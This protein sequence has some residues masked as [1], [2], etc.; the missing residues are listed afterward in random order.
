[1]EQKENTE[2]SKVWKVYFGSGFWKHHGRDRAGVEISVE[3]S[4]VWKDA[5][6]HVPAVYVCKA[7]LVVDFCIEIEPNRIRQFVKKVEKFGFEDTGLSPEEREALE[8]ENPLHIEFRSKVN[9]NGK[10]Y[11]FKKGYTLSWIPQSCRTEEMGVGEKEEV[12][13]LIA[14]YALDAERGWVICRHSFPWNYKRKPVIKKLSI[15]LEPRKTA[16]TALKF[17]M[18]EVGDKI[19]VKHPKSGV[20]HVITIEKIEPQTVK[21]SGVFQ[22]EW[23]YPDNFLMMSYTVTP[24]LSD[25]EFRITDCRQSDE[26]RRKRAADGIS[27]ACSIGI[28]GGASGPTAVFLSVKKPAED[29]H[30]ACSALRFEPAEEV[31]WKAVFHVKRCE[32]IELCLIGA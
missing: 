25:S 24:D 30:A 23:E 2:A 26:P 20:E 1:M 27:G 16:I 6:W 17:K 22:E 18:P 32:D 21:H 7:G 10:E 13:E 9:V 31:E 5:V 3:K 14:H 11:G 12:Q 15:M 29:L 4:F 19:S 28:I 8:N